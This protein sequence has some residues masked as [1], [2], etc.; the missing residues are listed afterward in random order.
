[1]AHLSGSQAAIPLCADPARASQEPRL[2][3]VLWS[4][5]WRNACRG[6]QPGV[7]CGWLVDGQRILKLVPETSCAVPAD[8]RRNFLTTRDGNRRGGNPEPPGKGQLLAFGQG[9]V[10]RHRC[11]GNSAP[12][13]IGRTPRPLVLGKV[14]Y[15]PARGEPARRN[16]GPSAQGKL[17]GA[18]RRG[19]PESGAAKKALG[20][21]RRENFKVRGGGETPSQVRRRKLWAVGEGTTSSYVAEGKLRVA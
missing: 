19:N 9:G 4:T 3:T 6:G 14:R 2:W 13:G 5:R 21:R 17:Q 12:P 8:G 10:W 20:Q 7:N 1:M 18:W 11:G 15:H 16:L